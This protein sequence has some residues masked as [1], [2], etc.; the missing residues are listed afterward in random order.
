MDRL[1]VLDMPALTNFEADGKIIEYI[2]DHFSKY[3]CDQVVRT[4]NLSQYNQ[5]LGILKVIPISS[6]E[7]TREWLKTNFH[8]SF[9]PIELP[10]ILMKYSPGYQKLTGEKLL[11][12]GYDNDK[13]FIKRID[14][15]KSWTSLMNPYESARPYINKNGL[16]AISPIH[17]ILAEYRLFIYYGKILGCQHYSGNPINFPNAEIISKMIYEY[18]TTKAP[19][20][21]TLDIMV[22]PE[23]TI[24]LEVHPFVACGLYGFQDI[25]LLDMWEKGLDW[26]IKKEGE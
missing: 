17:S 23:A 9:K 6:V 1:Y 20:A 14:Q 21:Y 8:I 12:L 3:N 4:D 2:C 10:E 24:P 13:Y 5:T 11:K 25:K 7:H 22:T 19:K 16:Y 18:Q 15:M 26:Y